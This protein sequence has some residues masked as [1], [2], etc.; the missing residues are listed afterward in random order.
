MAKT[1]IQKVLFKN[2]QPGV[3]YEL[4]MNAK[5]HSMVTGAAVSITAKEGS[6]YAAHGDYI[7]GKNLQ[8]IKNRLIVQSWRA[9]DWDENDIDATFIINLEPKGKDVVLHAIHANLPDKQAGSIDKG[10]HDYYWN[11]WKQYLAGKT[12]THAAM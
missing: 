9:S 7:K 3:L 8:L 12:I 2:T 5:K 4:Y 1:I 6:K 10:W 11:P